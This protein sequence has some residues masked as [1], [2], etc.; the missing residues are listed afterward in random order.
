MARSIGPVRPG[1]LVGVIQPVSSLSD[2]FEL[3]FIFYIDRFKILGE[4]RA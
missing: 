2:R 3:N 4:I 1:P